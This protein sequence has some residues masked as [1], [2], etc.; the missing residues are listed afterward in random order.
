VIVRAAIGAALL[1]AGVAASAQ[2]DPVKASEGAF[3]LRDFTFH[4]GKRLPELKLAYRTLGAPHRNAAGEIDNAVMVLHGTGGSGSNFLSP[5]MSKAL[6]APGAPLDQSRY[7]VILPDAIGHGESSRPSDGLRMAFPAYDYADMVGAQKR[8]LT[9]KLGIRKLKL[10]IGMSMGG[11]LTF[12]WATTYPDFAEK[13]VPMG[14]YPVEIAGQNRMTRKLEIDAIEGDPVW[15]GGNYKTQPLAGLRTSA[16]ISMLMGGSPLN[17]YATLPTR[18]AADKAL[19]TGIADRVDGT[20]AN[21]LIYQIDASS[22]YNPWDKLDRIK[23]PLLWINFADDQVN[24]ASL[25]VA[26]E[27]LKRMPNARFVL[28]AASKDTHGHGTLF[29]P[30]HWVDRL[31]AFM[32]TP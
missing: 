9:D 20:D 18:D 5:A 2:S 29:M 16:G 1:L 23:A 30:Q 11:M 19:E 10:I 6:F 8:L 12:Q 24:P 17:L 14:C 31:A 32:A 4:D 7:F 15:N 25:D 3:V 22:D 21:D 28:I 27:A 26:P 13:F